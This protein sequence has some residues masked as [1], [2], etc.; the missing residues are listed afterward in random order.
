LEEL[1]QLSTKIKYPA[2]VRDF[3]KEGDIKSTL[4]AVGIEIENSSEDVSIIICGSI[5]IMQPVKTVLDL[6]LTNDYN[7]KLN[8]TK[9]K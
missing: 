8:L 3:V 7:E 1:K 9:G 5:F 4:E 6:K 2:K